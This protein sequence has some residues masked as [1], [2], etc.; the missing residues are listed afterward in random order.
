LSRCKKGSNRRR[1][2]RDR[3]ALLQRRIANARSSY[4]H[5]VSARLAKTYAFIAVEKLQI[6]NMTGSARGTADEPGTNVRQKSGLNRALLDAA[7][8]KLLAY[9]SYK[10]ERAGGMVVK[11]EAAYSSQDC[12]SCDERVPKALSERWHR[13]S[14]GTLLHRD[15][16]AAINILKRALS[17]HGRARPPGDANVGH[18]PARRLG[19][20]VAEAA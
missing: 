16:N 19:K 6:K 8:A 2:V 9:T 15:H 5:Q 1:K 12:S 4:L 17:A 7:L 20:M 3:L 11:T 13:C 14:C 18:Q 10:A